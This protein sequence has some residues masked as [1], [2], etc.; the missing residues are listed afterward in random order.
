MQ[1]IQLGGYELTEVTIATSG[2][3]TQNLT[4]NR[5]YHFTGELTSL[6]I[7]F[8]PTAKA[9]HYNWDFSTGAT[10]PTFTVDGAVFN[11]LELEPNSHYEVDVFNGWGVIVPW[12]TSYIVAGD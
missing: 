11:Q 3:V 2:A 1:W 12:T 7:T 10:V 4:A 8:A 5:M 9:A 6:T